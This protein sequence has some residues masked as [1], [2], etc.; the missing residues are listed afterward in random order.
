MSHSIR[1]SPVG[2]RSPQVALA[3]RRFLAGAAGA[4][5][6]P[7]LIPGAAPGKEGTA[8]AGDRITVGVIG[9]GV[10]GSENLRGAMQSP[11]AEVVADRSRRATT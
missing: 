1:P 5:A 10:R 4:C 6:V 11:L 7:W 3:R 2:A 8:A 9:V